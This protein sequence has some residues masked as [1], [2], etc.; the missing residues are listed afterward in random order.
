MLF[1]L[2]TVIRL[3]E[4]GILRRLN[5][6]SSVSGGSITAAVL[7]LKWKLLDFKGSVAQKLGPEVV[8]LVR[9]MASKTIDAEAIIGGIL[10][11]GTISQ[12]IQKAY[13]EML[14][15]GA[16]LQDLPSDGEGPRFVINATSLQTG[17]LFRFSKPFMADYLVG[18][19]KS[20]KVSLAQAVAASSAFPPLL[21][22]SV[23]NVE[24]ADFVPDATC[25][26][27]EP[28]YTSEILLCD[29]GVYD[30][31]GLETAW[32]SYTTV[33]VSDGGAKLK[34][35][36]EP[37]HDWARQAYRILNI[38]D[39]QV[40]SLR[41]RQVIEAFKA[42]DHTGAYWGIRSHPEDYKLADSFNFSHDDINALAQIGTR[43]KSLDAETQ[44]RLINWGYAICDTAIRSHFDQT[45]P[46]GSLPYPG[47]GV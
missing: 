29:G 36:D 15:K 46:K 42:G 34:S 1:H 3:N 32:K 11:P 33:L 8:E 37:K 24:P 41:K 9:A 28:P 18:M 10:L 30:N 16:T 19:V 44:E 7:G 12:R 43:L 22:P 20:P 23:L 2:G 38:I 26:L 4:A 13:D 6:V 5:R 45:L 17:V 31:L 25:P 40:I 14:F 47:S 27:Q 35:E 39:N 21:S